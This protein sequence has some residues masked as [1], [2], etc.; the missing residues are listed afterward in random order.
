[1]VATYMSYTAPPTGFGCREIASISTFVLWMISAAFDM[2]VGPSDDLVFTKDLVF[3]L[4]ILVYN[5]YSH[6]GLFNRCSCWTKFHRGP[7]SFA[8]ETKV[9]AELHEK[10]GHE[11]AGAII[12][13]VTCQLVVVVVVC[14]LSHK[15]VNM[16]LSSVRNEPPNAD[17]KEQTGWQYVFSHVR[18]AWQRRRTRRVNRGINLRFRDSGEVPL[19]ARSASSFADAT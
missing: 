15:G 10:I 7:L 1:M 14:A 16:L 3:T 9:A 19:V 17:Q 18:R 5:I 11:W 4:G 8:L 12:F 13:L 6:L 2:W